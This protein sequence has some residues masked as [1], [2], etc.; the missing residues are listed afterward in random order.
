MYGLEGDT[1][2]V[3]RIRVD[4][5]VIVALSAEP[6]GVNELCVCTEQYTNPKYISPKVVQI[7]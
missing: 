1:A 3:H 4:S 6:P 5:L 2:D 7:L